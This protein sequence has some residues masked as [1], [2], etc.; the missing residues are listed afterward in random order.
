MTLL[1]L[2]LLACNSYYLVEQPAQSLLYMHRRWQLLCNRISF[3][4]GLHK[5]GVVA[6]RTQPSLCPG[7]RDE[8]LDAIARRVLAEEDYGHVQHAL[9]KSTRQGQAKEKPQGESQGENCSYPGGI[10]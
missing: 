4:T 9:H 2:L 5:T 6:C 1:V 3:A 7:L 10:I 8:L